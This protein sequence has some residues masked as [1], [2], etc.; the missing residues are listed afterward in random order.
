MQYD[1]LIV[2]AG[3]AGLS[4]AALLGR[5]G[6]KVGIIEREAGVGGRAQVLDNEGFI[7][8]Y[9]LHTYRLGPAGPL[10]RVLSELGRSVEFIE[11]RQTHYLIRGKDLL[12]L[13]RG[14]RERE[15]ALLFNESE[16]QEI[17]DW[18]P[19]PMR[20]DP[21]DWYSKSVDEYLSDAEEDS[22]IRRFAELMS[23]S[24]LEPDL[25]RVN[26]GLL[27]RYIQQG[28]EAG[29]FHADVRGGAGSIIEALRASI[30]E[31]DGE[32]ILDTQVQE[33]LLEDERVVSLSTSSG[34]YKASAVVYAAQLEK[35]FGLI[36]KEPFKPDFI[37]K[38]E[39]LK[40]SSGVVLDVALKAPIT[41]IRGFLFEPAEKMILRFPSNADPSLAPEGKQLMSALIL[42]DSE[43]VQD[44]N[45]VRKRIRKLRRVAAKLFPDFNDQVEWERILYT[46]VIDAAAPWKKQG[47]GTRPKVSV[48]QVPNLFFAGDSTAAQGLGSSIAFESALEATAAVK[49]YLGTLKFDSRE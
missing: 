44:K 40:P 47:P 36:D 15:V 17:K 6:Y 21:K 30:E 13:P 43:Q 2:G 25:A 12:A 24:M 31:S 11:G 14:D 33:I 37:R 41:D 45:L 35:L 39:K 9:G 28:A 20:A 38:C 32:L 26:A 49:K 29:M 10:S 22:P 27:I 3:F 34:E 16:W 1:V 5:S 23:F 19:G 4:A 48:K 46:P 7:L 18:L 42:L 8:D